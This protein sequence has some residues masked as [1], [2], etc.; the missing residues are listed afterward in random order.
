MINELKNK[1]KAVRTICL[2]EIKALNELIV[3][4]LDS[5]K[6]YKTSVKEWLKPVVDLKDFYVYPING[7]TE[8]LNWW[9]GNETRS[10]HM[11]DGDY[12]WVHQTKGYGNIFYMSNP[13]AI[14]GNW[15][16][17]PE[18]ISIALDLAYVGSTAIRKIE[19]PSNVEYVFY[20]LSKSFGV[21]NIRTGWLF[22]RKKIERLELLTYNAKYYNYPAIE[23]SEAIMNKYNIDYVYNRLR[24]NQI[25]FCEKF[26]LVPSDSVH[27]A[28]TT[29]E[30]FSDFR[31]NKKIARLCI[32]EYLI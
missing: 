21:R 4:D 13:S 25:N 15:V 26:D 32:S 8:G 29:S 3:P 9:M 19:L 23:L 7:I 5:V 16:N 24:E 6:E 11:T 17:I 20:S 14:D 31:R 18:N 2:P 12:Q 10:I 27:I 22:S 1:S 30:E 28:T